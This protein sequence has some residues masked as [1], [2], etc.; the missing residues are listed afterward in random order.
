[1]RTLFLFFWNHRFL[2][3]FLLLE[4][5]SVILLLNSY[6]YQKSLALNT[7]N[8]ITGNMFEISSNISDYF[9]LQKQ[10]AELLEENT[11]LHNILN[12]I[13]QTD[14][15]K[16]DSVTGDSTFVYIFAKVISN[17]VNKRNNYIMINKGRNCDIEKEMAVVSKNG[18]VGIVTGV[19][20]H[21][22]IIMSMLHQNTTIS[23]RIKKNNQLVN[24]V[25]GTDNY[26]TGTVK[27]IPSHLELF[28][29]DTVITSGNSLIFPAGINIGTIEKYVADSLINL[30]SATLRFST[31]FNALN[32]VYIIKNNAKKEQQ[33]LIKNTAE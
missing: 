33:S 14:S 20:N 12:N 11:K 29:G 22:A 4:T 3:L 21:Y 6:S 8:D 25:W 15:L 13:R 32:Y 17:S 24:V 10:N 31:D 26:K 30:N 18:L 27:D 19:S 9:S 1:M 23:A 5:V 7:V 28:K 2:T 16:N